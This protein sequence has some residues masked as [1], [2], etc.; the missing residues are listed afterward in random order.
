MSCS[1]NKCLP[2]FKVMKNVKKFEW[3]VACQKAFED[4][5]KLLTS[6][7]LLSRPTP[8]EM[9]YLYLSVGN[10]SL[11]SELIREDK[12]EQN[13]I[14]YVSKVLRG[15]EI[16][17]PKM[18]KLALALVHAARNLYHYFQAHKIVVR[19]CQPLRKIL[20]RPETFGRLVQ[21]SVQ[22]GEHD[23]LYEP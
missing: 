6:P 14:Y 20:Q 21:W 10:E 8:G 17:Y 19:T 2:F 1:A 9:L 4:I 13:S 23:I 16:R 12:G 3:N 7:P 18:D 22:L 11:T 5:K 15:L